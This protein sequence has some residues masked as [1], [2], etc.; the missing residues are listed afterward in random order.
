MT[1]A[2][3]ASCLSATCSLRKAAGRCSTCSSGSRAGRRALPDAGREA[4]GR[5]RQGGLVPLYITMGR[6]EDGEKFCAVLRDITAWKRTEEELIN[7]QP[8]G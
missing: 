5:V 4:I 1:Q 8:G 7:A 6:I 3:S 2:N